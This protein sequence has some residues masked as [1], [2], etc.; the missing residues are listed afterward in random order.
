MGCGKTTVGRA[1]ADRLSVPFIDLDLAFE[2]MWGKTVREA[3]ET[4]GE[5]WFRARE[6]ELLRGTADLPDAV[7][8]LGGGTF[9]GSEN[10]AFVKRHGLSVFLDLPFSAIVSRLAG[11]AADRP[12]FQ[13]VEQAARLYESRLPCYKIADRTIPLSETDSVDAVVEQL[14]AA[15]PRGASASVDER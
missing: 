14:L 4:R 5:P 6:G 10:V 13:S 3:F 1:L 8:A 7:V 9:V 11:K 12:L 15:L 2:A